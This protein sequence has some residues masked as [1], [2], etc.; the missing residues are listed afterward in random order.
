MCSSSKMLFLGKNYG[1]TTENFIQYQ[2]VEFLGYWKEKIGYYLEEEASIWWKSLDSEILKLC[3]V[4]EIEELFL[5]KWSHTRKKETKKPSKDFI[6][7]G[8]KETKKPKGLF[9]ASISL[10]QVHELI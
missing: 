3:H 4:H 7:T 6:F 10:L 8:K 9:S 2:K 1:P 5:D